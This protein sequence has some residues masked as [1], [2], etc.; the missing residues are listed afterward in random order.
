MRTLIYT[1]I[2][3]LTA[4]TLCFAQE[5]LKDGENLK[6]RYVQ[7]SF[8]TITRERILDNLKQIK[9]NKH[10]Q[11]EAA[12]TAWSNRVAQADSV[13]LSELA[14][15]KEEKDRAIVVAN[16]VYER[17]YDKWH[18][19]LLAAYDAD[20]ID[21]NTANDALKELRGEVKGIN[22]SSDDLLK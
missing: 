9:V 17:D 13:Y 14:K 22:W 16:D 4:A 3:M 8:E 19:L 18:T 11:I 6:I 10:Y 20:V 21:K 1:I 7:E 15:A 5:Y 2:F 12:E